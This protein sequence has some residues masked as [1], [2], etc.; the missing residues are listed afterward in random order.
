M[1][2]SPYENNSAP[3][4]STTDQVWGGY[5]HDRTSHPHRHARRFVHRQG[6]MTRPG[7]STQSGV[8]AVSRQIRTDEL[9]DALKMACDVAV[10]RCGGPRYYP[11]RIWHAM[12]QRPKASPIR[13]L[14][15]LLG[16][17]DTPSFRTTKE[18]PDGT[19]NVDTVACCCN[20]S[21]GGR[22]SRKGSWGG[23]SGLVITALQLTECTEHDDD[24]PT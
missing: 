21:H 1:L 12:L 13:P 19:A 22:G 10:R 7:E 11:S 3:F 18:T 8:N 6:I 9:P 5:R 23:S 15:V 2:R 4:P 24:E 16:S 14:G 20:D 17:P